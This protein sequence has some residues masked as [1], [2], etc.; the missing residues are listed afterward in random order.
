MSHAGCACVKRAKPLSDQP[1]LYRSGVGDQDGQRCI[2]A[3]QAAGQGS[4]TIFHR[5]DQS[6]DAGAACQ[7]QLDAVALIKRAL[8]SHVRR[9][10]RHAQCEAARS[11]DQGCLGHWPDRMQD[12]PSSACGAIQGSRRSAA[13]Q[14]GRTRIIRREPRLVPRP[15]QRDGA[16]APASPWGRPAGSCP[17][18][19]PSSTGSHPRGVIRFP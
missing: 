18:R 17:S 3:V 15:P 4:R 9:N 16:E 6:G 13:P 11:G 1:R 2:L 7:V 5:H 8:D 12:P 19:G 10:H 14:R